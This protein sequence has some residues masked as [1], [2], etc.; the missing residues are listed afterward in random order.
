MNGIVKGIPKGS[1]S[2]MIDGIV[3]GLPLKKKEL[4]VPETPKVMASAT[5]YSMGVFG[6]GPTPDGDGNKAGSE[7]G[8]RSHGGV[9]L[10]Y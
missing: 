4:S 5:K 6:A 8:S 10:V 2:T 3:S 1:H 9:K 7:K